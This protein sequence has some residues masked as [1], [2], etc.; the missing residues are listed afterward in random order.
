M[1]TNQGRAD[2]RESGACAQADPDLFFPISSAGR[3][4]GQI[5]KAKAICAGCPVRRRCLDF[6]LEHDLMYG[7][8]GGSTPLDRQAWQRERRR[9]R[10]QS[11]VPPGREPQAYPQPPG[12]RNSRT[13]C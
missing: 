9:E 4:L 8:W 1:T 6:A 13:A 10:L 3:S 12:D 11:R 7:I 2:W 5:A